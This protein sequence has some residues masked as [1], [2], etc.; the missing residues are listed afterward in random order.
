MKQAKPHRRQRPGPQLDAKRTEKSRSTAVFAGSALVAMVLVTYLPVRNAGFIMDDDVNIAANPTLYSVDGLRRIWLEPSAVQQYYPL[1]HTMFWVE[2][3]LWGFHP[4]GYHLVNVLLHATNAV[5]VWRLLLALRV[6]GAWVAAAIFAV[7]PVEVE[8]VAWAIERKNVLSLALALGSMLCYL[9]FAPPEQSDD[10]AARSWGWYAASIVLFAAA[11]FAK[12][13]VSTMPA[14][15]LVVYWWKRGRITLR[16]FLQ[17]VPF[18]VLALCLGSITIWVE[19][20]GVG[21]Q[22][23]DWSYTFVERVLLAGRAVWFYARK[24]VWPWPVMFFYPRWPADA[25]VWWQYLFPL[26]AVAVPVVLWLARKRIGRGPLAAALIFGGVLVPVLG[27]FSI[28]FQVF[29]FVADHFEYHASV[30][31]IALGAAAIV[32]LLRKYEHRGV[33]GETGP[34]DPLPAALT[35]PSGA[36]GAV[37]VGAVLLVFGVSSFRTALLYRDPETLYRDTIRKNPDSWIAHSNLGL[38]L[39]GAGRFD[40]AIAELQEAARKNPTRPRVFYNYGKILVDRGQQR[41]FATGELDEAID[42]FKRALSLGPDWVA[43]YV[44]LGF[45][46]IRAN[47]LEEAAKSLGRALE[48]DP[49]YVDG[50][51]AM[52][53]LEAEQGRWAESQAWYEKALARDPSRAEVHYGLGFA[54]TNRGDLPAAVEEFSEAVHLRPKY[55]EA[56]NN[57]GITLARLGELDRAIECFQQVLR[58]DPGSPQAKANLARALAA[59]RGA[60]N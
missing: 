11:L 34:Y 42:Q 4:L 1:V 56:W 49:N 16:D 40:E 32:M 47:R 2:S 31:L 10:S 22:G 26:S 51:C 55:S 18:F 44:G 39:A 28:Y 17:L 27:F 46:M 50:L 33:P 3:R 15:L 35:K 12:T 29:T 13:V 60:Q 53:M 9:R 5:L 19:R 6:P 57:L 38:D 48:I 52:G 23:N 7:H 30:A 59:R 37:L 20:Y 21:A 41:G 58:I 24:L 8:S 43:P 36:A 45:A 54:L 25:G 14:V